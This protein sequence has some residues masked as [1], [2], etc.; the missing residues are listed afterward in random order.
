M[1]VFGHI[2]RGWTAPVG[3]LMQ[4]SLVALPVSGLL[5]FALSALTGG[6]FIVEIVVIAVVQFLLSLLVAGWLGTRAG[7]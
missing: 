3:R 7:Q 2:R 6:P 1:T 5:T 4:A